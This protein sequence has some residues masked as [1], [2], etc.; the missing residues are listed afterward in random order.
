MLLVVHQKSNLMH[1][2]PLLT[3][4]IFSIFLSHAQHIPNG[5]F[6]SWEKRD[7]YKLDSWY[8]YNNTVYRTSDSKIGKYAI[9]LENKYSETSNGS[10]G[11]ATNYRSDDKATFGG[12]AFD[13][14]PLSLAFWS[15]HNLALGDTA[16][17]YVEFREKGSYKGRVDFRFAGSTGGDFVKYR[18]PIQWNGARNPDTVRITLYSKVRSKIQ[19]DG[20]VIYD[21]IHFENIGKRSPNIVNSSFENWQN[22]GIDY[23]L[24]WKSIDLRYYDDYRNFYT[25][26]SVYKSLKEDAFLGNHSLVVKNY[27][28]GSNIRYGYCY[29]GSENDH[30]YRP[31]F[32]FTDTFKYIQ[33]YYKYLPE[34]DDTARLLVRTYAEGSTRSSNNLYLAKADS[35]T[36]FSIPLTYNNNMTPDSASFVIYSAIPKDTL[37]N[38]TTLYIDN[39]DFVMKP[40]PLTLSTDEVTHRVKTY[41]NPTEDFI[42]LPINYNFKY[43][44]L[45]DMLGKSISMDIQDQKLDLRNIRTGIYFVT[46]YGDKIQSDTIKVLKK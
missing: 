16:R 17:I 37:G 28:S 25:R 30:S 23:P 13:D 26:Q 6:E 14:E 12:A 41:P 7:H 46:L 11:Y 20:Y 4:L 31:A 10:R 1:R 29:L 5:D 3:I 34:R 19:G 39:L 43:A 2:I 38:A 45:R 33:G 40:T 35:W 15:K 24:N 44:I 9:K 42:F 8:S 27:L 36:F 18:I 22:I 21:D 32:P